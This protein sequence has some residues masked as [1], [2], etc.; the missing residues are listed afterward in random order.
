MRFLSARRACFLL[1][2]CGQVWQVTAVSAIDVLREIKA[3]PAAEQEKLVRLLAEETDWLE[4]AMDAA[5]AK[6]RMDEP[7]RPVEM[8]LREQGLG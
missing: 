7:E 8:L 6:A 2:L 4:D 5:I 1:C 3:L